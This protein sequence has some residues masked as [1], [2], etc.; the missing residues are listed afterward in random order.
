[1]KIKGSVEFS[2]VEVIKKNLERIIEQKG[3]CATIACKD[4]IFSSKYAE[5]RKVCDT[6]SISKLNDKSNA[7]AETIKRAR[8][9]LAEIEENER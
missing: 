1:M 7:M 4:C 9:I 2:N 8:E 5:D 6:N 3:V